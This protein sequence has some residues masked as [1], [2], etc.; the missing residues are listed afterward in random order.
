MNLKCLMSSHVWDGCKCTR[1]GK[2]RDE[3]HDWSKDCEKCAWCGF[4]RSDKHDWSK[5]CEKCTRCGSSRSGAHDWSKDCEKCTKCFTTRHNAHDWSKNYEQQCAQCGKTRSYRE[6]NVRFFEAEESER[7]ARKVRSI[8]CPICNVSILPERMARH[9]AQCKF[10]QKTDATLKKDEPQHDLKMTKF[11]HMKSIPLKQPKA[12]GLSWLRASDIEKF[13]LCLTLKKEAAV[14]WK[15]VAELF[16]PVWP[17]VEYIDKI[18][19]EDSRSSG[20]YCK[21]EIGTIVSSVIR[22]LDKKYTKRCCDRCGTEDGL[23][24]TV[25]LDN[26]RTSMCCS[27]VNKAMS[28]PFSSASKMELTCEGCS[29]SFS[30]PENAVMITTRQALQFMQQ[31]GVVTLGGIETVGVQ[32]DLVDSI[33]KTPDERKDI[34]RK[35]SIEAIQEIRKG[36][37]TGEERYWVCRLCREKNSYPSSMKSSSRQCVS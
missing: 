27:C 12:T 22:D 19:Q 28:R 15:G 18:L 35:Q 20:E 30:I 1:C 17:L 33:D 36:L 13:D 29:H 37:A 26:H 14:L 24:V 8:K 25:L 6:A 23:F 21:R 16:V 7:K 9:E 31:S 10:R 4:A 34:V 5:D 3:G 2:T 11:D 32:E